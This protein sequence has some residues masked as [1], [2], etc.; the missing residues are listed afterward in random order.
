MRYVYPPAAPRLLLRLGGA[1]ALALMLR[2]RLR[3]DGDAAGAGGGG[4]EVRVGVEDVEERGDRG[5][6]AALRGLVR[7][8]R[9][10]RSQRR[11]LPATEIHVTGGRLP[12]AGC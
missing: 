8:R 10:E 2:R 11:R 3:E 5:V 4:E 1:I 7:R 9:G 6:D 12:F